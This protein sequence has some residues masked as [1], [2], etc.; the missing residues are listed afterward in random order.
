MQPAYDVSFGLYSSRV[1][2][3]LLSSVYYFEARADAEKTAGTRTFLFC[4]ELELGG[5]CIVVLPVLT[6]FQLVSYVS[7]I[8]R[9]LL[10]AVLVFFS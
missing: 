6:V 2:R 9:A 7:R 10:K 3:S 5:R 8:Q 4:Y 1:F